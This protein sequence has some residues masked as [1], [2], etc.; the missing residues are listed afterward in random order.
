MS[1]RPANPSHSSSRFLR[2]LRPLLAPAVPRGNLGAA[3][4][5]AGAGL[6]CIQGVSSREASLAEPGSPW[7]TGMGEGRGWGRAGVI[8]HLRGSWDPKSFP[9]P[10][11][12]SALSHSL[13]ETCRRFPLV[14][15]LE[16]VLDESSLGIPKGWILAVWARAS[17]LP[18]ENVRLEQL[19]VP[20][21]PRNWRDNSSLSDTWRDKH[22]GGSPGMSPGGRR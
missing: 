5:H 14:P 9:I 1:P 13:R 12:S 4:K 20:A 18:N 11:G 21:Q 16:L 8:N 19:P 15:A 6:G 10:A 3:S 22:S 7:D 17:P 2:P